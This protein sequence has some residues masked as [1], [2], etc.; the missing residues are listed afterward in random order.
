MFATSLRL[1]VRVH[2]SERAVVRAAAALINQDARH[3]PGLREARKAFYRDMLRHHTA[4]RD[5]AARHRL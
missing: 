3:D 5:L 2:V 1:H 4:C